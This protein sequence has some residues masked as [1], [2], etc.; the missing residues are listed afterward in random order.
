[1][2]GYKH[3]FDDVL[4]VIFPVFFVEFLRAL[5]ISKGMY[6]Q[7][8]GVDCFGKFSPVKLG[9]FELWSPT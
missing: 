8:D 9:H 7:I 5:A 1:M 3:W 6:C 4:I 2:V